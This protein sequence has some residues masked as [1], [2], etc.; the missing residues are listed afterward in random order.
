MKHFFLLAVLLGFGL[1]AIAAPVP[2]RPLPYDSL[3]ATV[4]APGISDSARVYR[5][6]IAYQF[7][8]SASPDTARYYV[9]NA[10]KLAKQ[11]HWLRGEAQCYGGLAG[12]ASYAHQNVAAQHWFQQ[13]LRVAQLTHN[14]GL[15]G[16][17][18]VGMASLAIKSGNEAEGLAYYDRARATFAN[19]RP[20][21]TNNELLVLHNLANYYLEH[22][23]PTLA[24]PLVRQ[25]MGLVTPRNYPEVRVGVLLLL[26]SVQRNRQQL[27]SAATTLRRAAV[28]AQLTY[29]GRQA[30]EAHSLLADLLLARHQ[31]A[32]AL[33]EA[34]QALALARACG[35]LVLVVETMRVQAAAMQALHLPGSYDTLARYTVLRDTLQ[36]QENAEAVAEAQARFNDAEKEARISRLEQQQRLS[37][38]SGELTRLRTQR[39]Q[40]AGLALVLLTLLLAGGVLWQYRRRQARREAALRHQIAADLHDDVGS[41]L[42]QISLQ[43][44]LMT[45]G[46]HLPGE[47]QAHLTRMAEASRTAVRQMSDVVWGLS[48]PGHAATLGPLLARMREHAH[49]LLPPAGLEV[50]FATDPVLENTPLVTECQ[51]AMFLIFKEALH[52]AVKHAHNATVVRVRVQATPTALHL[53]V[54][55][56]GSPRPLRTP[57]LG[58]QGIISMQGR[59]QAVGGSMRHKAHDT[60]FEVSVRLPLR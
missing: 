2:S 19:A 20:R 41:L 49:E 17:A 8:V 47:Q 50:D 9:E 45:H 32:S 25:A 6:L 58:G 16:G 13:Q 60:G 28:L 22:D 39:Q 56:N 51:Q 42:T 46:L 35:A 12:L 52:N 26:A 40:V 33:A 36:A 37:A 29:Q 4:R 48:E 14:V 57:H 31:P 34:R 43:S 15:T 3:R 38:Q 30:A 54:T 18:Y 11:M 59:A 27:D 10:L 55:D 5:Q 21:D 7:L 53:T 44:E 1:V 24:A 23:Q